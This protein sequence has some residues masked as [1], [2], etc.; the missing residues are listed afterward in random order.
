MT[1]L[2]LRTLIAFNI[3]LATNAMPLQAPVMTH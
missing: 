3:R 1:E 2:F